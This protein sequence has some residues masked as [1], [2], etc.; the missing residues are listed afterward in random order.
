MSRDFTPKELYYFEQYMLKNNG[1]SILEVMKNTTVSYDGEV[2][3]F[4]SAESISHCE[5]FPLLGSLLNDFDS[6]YIPL[7]KSDF[8]FEFLRTSE[9]ALRE[10]ISSGIGETSS[11]LIQ[12]FEGKLDKNFY[13]SGHNEKLFVE[14]TLDLFKSLISE[15]KLSLESKISD[16]KA[17]LE[18]KALYPHTKPDYPER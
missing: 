4:R 11:L 1:M 12:W 5:E 18:E 13:Y 3:P 2:H 14:G 15:K 10:Y 16:A 6:L 7:S 17:S 9:D 8:G